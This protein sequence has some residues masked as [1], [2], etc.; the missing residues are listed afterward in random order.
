MVKCGLSAQDAK[1]ASAGKFYFMQG[2]WND[3]PGYFHLHV[4]EDG[5]QIFYGF[6]H[7]LDIYD[8]DVELDPQEFWE[9]YNKSGRLKSASVED[10]DTDDFYHRVML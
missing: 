3:L 6:S 9:I 7:H 1:V 2:T 10:T 5:R 4:G 8:D